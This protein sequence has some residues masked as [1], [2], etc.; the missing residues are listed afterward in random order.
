MP[1]YHI[2]L[3]KKHCFEQTYT[4]HR[5]SII[6]ISFFTILHNSEEVVGG[7][8]E[9]FF[10][11][12][13]HFIVVKSPNIQSS[14]VFFHDWLSTVCD[15]TKNNVLIHS[16]LLLYKI[17]FPFMDLWKK[18]LCKIYILQKKIPSNDLGALILI[19]LKAISRNTRY[20][21]L[22]STANS[23]HRKQS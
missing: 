3:A 20:C 4:L 6:I 2:R 16:R 15:M 1:E 7:P 11:F 9:I 12:L 23:H 13:F 8:N 5:V 22:D 17:I 18:N 21:G 10:S 19:I 14:T